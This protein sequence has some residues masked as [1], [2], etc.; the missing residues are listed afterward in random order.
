MATLFMLVPLIA[1]PVMAISGIPQFAPVVA[2]TVPGDDLAEQP[3]TMAGVGESARPTPP[4]VFAP[5]HASNRSDETTDAP[6]SWGMPPSRDMPPTFSE[7]PEL[8]PEDDAPF[9]SRSTDR[10]PPAVDPPATSTALDERTSS[11][12][13]PSWY[14][15]RTAAPT[16]DEKPVA[17]SG[18]AGSR[19]LEESS[20]SRDSSAATEPPRTPASPA[21]ATTARDSSGFLVLNDPAHPSA[22]S[23][24]A[25]AETRGRN[26][27]AP[28]SQE[29]AT[30]QGAVKRLNELGIHQF[31]LEPGQAANSFQFR[32]SLTRP[33][34][35]QVTRRFEAEAGDPLE[36]VQQVLDQVE[37]WMGR[38]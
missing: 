3:I 21:A 9:D 6:N 10:E 14:N 26:G 24:P 28:A 13:A 23:P 18:F 32:C 36:A 25:R 34:S 33:D 17:E 11:G 7:S 38:Q 12:P 8:Q 16:K 37:D 15:E 29:K 19:N 20:L 27:G 31:H 4:D 1:V 35:P 30:W 2:S 5:H 22:K